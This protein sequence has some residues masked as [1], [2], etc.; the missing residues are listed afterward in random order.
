MKK[1]LIMAAMLLGVY[2]GASAQVTNIDVGFAPYDWS[3]LTLEGP[4]GNDAKLEYM[5]ETMSFSLAR[6]VMLDG[7]PLLAEL[8]YTTGKSFDYDEINPSPLFTPNTEDHS[9]YAVTVLTMSGTTL[10]KK[11][12]LQFPLY[13]GIGGEYVRAEKVCHNLA[14]VVA[15]KARM[16]F[17]FTNSVSAFVGFNAQY[18]IGGVDLNMPVETDGRETKSGFL[19]HGRTFAEVGLTFQLKQK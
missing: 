6:E 7:V 17:Y 1:V 14:F 4:S 19:G 8:R 15:A 3:T 18:A 9:M 16:K 5:Y 2:G 11:K 10:N 12:R 13:I